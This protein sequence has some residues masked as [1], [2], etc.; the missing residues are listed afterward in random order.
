MSWQEE[1]LDS[2]T[3]MITEDGD[4]FETVAHVSLQMATYFMEAALYY[5]EWAAAFVRL[6]APDRVTDPEFAAF[7]LTKVFPVAMPV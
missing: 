1:T 5:P 3:E 7:E 2:W 4:D 6:A